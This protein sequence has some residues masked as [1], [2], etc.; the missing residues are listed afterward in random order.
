MTLYV[1]Y[2]HQLNKLFRFEISPTREN[3]KDVWCMILFMIIYVHLI[4]IKKV[5]N[6]AAKLFCKARKH[7]YVQS[8]LQTLHWLS[9]QARKHYSQLPVTASSLTH[10]LPISAYLLTVYDPVQAASGS[11]VL[12]QTRIHRIPHV[13]AKTFGQRCFPYC[14]PRQW[15]FVL[16][17]ICHIQFPPPPPPHALRTA[18][19]F[20]FFLNRRLNLQL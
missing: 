16:S 4:I 7:D 9:V 13:R 3:R 1:K 20:F 17:D 15:K 11:F 18:F 5:Q 12:L 19:N 8:F 10:P 6:S 2:F 14:A